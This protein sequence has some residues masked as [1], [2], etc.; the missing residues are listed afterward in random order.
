[1]A[2]TPLDI[3][4]KTFEKH[5]NGLSKTEV[6]EFLVL[7]A[8]EIEE[9][10]KERSHLVE[11]VEELN[12]KLQGYE[13]TE[14]LLKDTLITAQKATGE[15]RE[16]AKK[17]AEMVVEKAKLEAE[18]IRL[19]AQQ[20]ARNLSEELRTLEM[21]RSNLTDEIA[22]IARTYLAMAERISDRKPSAERADSAERPGNT[23]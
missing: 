1:M 7:V 13:K 5:R 8:D 4:K 3:R 11:K 19:E 10:R 2:I 9:L 21:K 17:E 18:R 14:Q 20:Q 23:D 6:E 22:G 16:G 15:L 12:G